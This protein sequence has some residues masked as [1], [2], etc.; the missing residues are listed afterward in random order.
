[1]IKHN[2]YLLLLVLLFTLYT[3]FL[4]CIYI[5]SAVEDESRWI[6][7]LFL[8]YSFKK[9]RCSELMISL[10]IRSYFDEPGFH[11]SLINFQKIY[12]RFKSDIFSNKKNN[13]IFSKIFF[14]YYVG[15]SQL[16]FSIHFLNRILK[17]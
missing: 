8:S 2:L 7:L 15:C 10:M 3:S 17:T 14:C 11:S 9:S 5:H 1:M 13:E 4:N 6:L 16:A 12:L